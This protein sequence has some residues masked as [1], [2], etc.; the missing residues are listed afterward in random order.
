MPV[1]SDGKKGLHFAN[2]A[3]SE[4]SAFQEAHAPSDL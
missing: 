1:A 2:D 3:N 4:E